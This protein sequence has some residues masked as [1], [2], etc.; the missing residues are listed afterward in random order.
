[1]KIILKFSFIKLLKKL[2]VLINLIINLD[3]IWSW[4]EEEKLSNP[5]I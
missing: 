3:H 4:N 2:K 5:L 1:M